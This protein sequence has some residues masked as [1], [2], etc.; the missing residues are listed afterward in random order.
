MR[1]LRKIC[2]ALAIGGIFLILGDAKYFSDYDRYN[3]FY[4]FNSFHGDIIEGFK[5]NLKES[6]ARKNLI[7]SKMQGL[8]GHLKH[9]IEI[10]RHEIKCRK[11]YMC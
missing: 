2:Y 8:Q 1:W 6:I 10:Y 7:C 9:R 4:L 3:Y 11:Q 5:N